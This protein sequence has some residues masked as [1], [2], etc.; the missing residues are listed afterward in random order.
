MYNDSE[1]LVFYIYDLPFDIRKK[2]FLDYLQTGFRYKKIE[3]ILSMPESVA[4]NYQRLSK[5]IPHILA[6]NTLITYLLKTDNIFPKIYE[7][8]IL[9]DEKHFELLDPENGFALAWLMYLYH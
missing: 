4:L 2:I 5:C 1:L 6:S 9:R 7:K 3:K 8:H